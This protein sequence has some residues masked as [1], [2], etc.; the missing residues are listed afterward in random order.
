MNARSMLLGSMLLSCASAAVAAAS[1]CRPEIVNAW[2][3]AVPPGATTLAGY[4]NVRNSCRKQAVLVAVSGVDFGM[5]TLHETRIESGISKMQHMDALTI[6]AGVTAKLEPGGQHLMLMQPRRE[7]RE[8]DRTRLTF[9]LDDGSKV[10][11]DFT[12]RR[13]APKHQP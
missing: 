12:V 9:R 2:I 10:T 1:D 5:A 8:G 13:Q 6:P 11:A 3:R 4:A 7:L